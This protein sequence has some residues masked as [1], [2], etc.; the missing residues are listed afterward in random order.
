M[1]RGLGAAI[2]KRLADLIVARA[3][4]SWPLLSLVP[5]SWIRPVVQPTATRLRRALARG[6]LAIAVPI[7][8]VVALLTLA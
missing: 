6:G 3:R 1:D 8:V 4:R 2:D 7:A 5:R